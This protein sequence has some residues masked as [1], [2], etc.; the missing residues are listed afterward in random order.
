[1]TEDQ[2]VDMM[3]RARTLEAVR[4]ARQL[5]LAFIKNNPDSCDKVIS[6]GSRLVMME[7]S[8]ASAGELLGAIK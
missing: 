1:M 8:L 5:S 2:V 3:S 7:R 4:K 6:A